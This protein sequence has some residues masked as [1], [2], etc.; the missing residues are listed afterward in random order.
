MKKRML[1]PLTAV[2]AGAGGLIGYLPYFDHE[3]GPVLRVDSPTRHHPTA[4][5]A[6]GTMREARRGYY[7]MP[8]TQ[9]PF[10]IGLPVAHSPISRDITAGLG[11]FELVPVLDAPQSD[12]PVP[13]VKLARIEIVL[14]Q[15]PMLPRPSTDLRWHTWSDQTAK[16]DVG[17]I[18]ESLGT[19]TGDNQGKP[20]A[21]PQSAP[22]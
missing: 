16:Q 11:H 9:L 19:P 18:A 15:G 7:H 12:N 6:F 10:Y 17:D 3:T 21:T 20:L 22:R 4:V 13:E 2:L 1:L 14:P 8:A 5:P